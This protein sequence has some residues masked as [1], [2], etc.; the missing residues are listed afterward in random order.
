MISQTINL[1]FLIVLGNSRF[2]FFLSPSRSLLQ[3]AK[4]SLSC[5]CCYTNAYALHRHAIAHGP[6]CTLALIGKQRPNV[7]FRTRHE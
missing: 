2:L 7:P 1:R 5:R 4:I 6:L 3:K